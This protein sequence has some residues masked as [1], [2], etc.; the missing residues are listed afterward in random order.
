MAANPIDAGV[1]PNHHDVTELEITCEAVGSDAGLPFPWREGTAG[2]GECALRRVL[3]AD[4]HPMYATALAMAVQTID[5]AILVDSAGT[6]AEA[7]ALVRAHPHDLVLLDLMLPDVQGFSGL[8]LLRAIKPNTPVGIVSSR[9]EPGVIRQAAA[10]GAQGFLSKASPIDRVVSAIRVLL[11]GGQWFPNGVT[12]GGAS[13]QTAELAKRMGTLSVAQLRVLRAIASGRQNKQIAHDLD[14]AEPTIKSHLSAIFRK[15]GVT[16][17]TQA[18]LQLQLLEES[19]S[20]L[21]S[22]DVSR[23]SRADDA[24]SFAAASSLESNAS[25]TS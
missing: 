23:T 2:S 7:E 8:A 18:V 9:D 5:S 25:L 15:L 14:L 1:K 6:L 17:R 11:E 16:N 24:T 22:F 13:D 21:A 4:D 19:E 12:L 3:V 10:L 20:S